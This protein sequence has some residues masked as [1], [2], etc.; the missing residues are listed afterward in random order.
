MDLNFT[1]THFI[2]TFQNAAEALIPCYSLPRVLITATPT[3]G[4]GSHSTMQRHRGQV[5]RHLLDKLWRTLVMDGAESCW[6]AECPR[7][8]S[9]LLK[10]V[11]QAV[12]QLAQKLL[13]TKSRLNE[14][15]PQM[16]FAS[17]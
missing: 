14:G 17:F 10:A 6:T 5:W 3:T 2:G 16:Q 9:Y 12:T 15:W 13:Q 4:Q 8:T 1:E 11:A 7:E